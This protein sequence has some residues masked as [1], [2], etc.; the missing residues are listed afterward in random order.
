MVCNRNTRARKTWSDE[1]L[2]LFFISLDLGVHMAQHICGGQ[3]ITCE[4][5][6]SPPAVWAVWTLAGIGL[7]ASSLATASL[8]AELSY[9]APLHDF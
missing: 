4:S 6:F 9:W 1:W 2:L 7:R 5:P 8:P 3:M